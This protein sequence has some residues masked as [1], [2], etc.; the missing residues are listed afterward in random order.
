M[1]EPDPVEG[2]QGT[3]VSTPDGAQFDDCFVLTGD[4]SVR[5]G[6]SSAVAQSGELELQDTLVGL[7]DTGTSF[8]VWGQLL[9]GVPDTNGCQ[10]QVTQI[11]ANGETVSLTPPD[12]SSESPQ[13]ESVG[14]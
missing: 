7:R 4:Y 3:L 2:W 12:A 14:W 5:Y 10:I 8:R 13:S 1:S 9:C 11:E 6:I